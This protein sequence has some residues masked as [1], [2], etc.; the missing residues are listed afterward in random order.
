MTTIRRSNWPSVIAVSWLWFA[1]LLPCQAFLSPAKIAWKQG[2]STAIHPQHPES[3][4]RT[5]QPLQ[6]YNDD[7]EREQI[8]EA[9][10]RIWNSRRGEVRS[11]LKGAESL[12]NFRLANGFVPEL[13][14]DGNPSKSDGK[15]AVTLT[16]FAVAAGAIVL[17]V[18]GRAA[19]VSAVGLDFVNDNPEMQ[20]QINQVLQYAETIDPILKTGLFCL[21]WT[22]VK[23]LC[24][25]AGGI[26]LAFASGILFGG[27]VQGAVMSALGATIG[28]SVAFALA[29][30]DTPVREKA[31]EIV[32][33]NPS[34]RGLEKVVAEE[35][36]KAV[37]TF[38]LAPVLPIPLGMYNYV[39]GITNVRFVDFAGGI[40]LGSLKPY[41]LDSYLGYFGK[42][43]V[44]GTANEGG[45]QDYVLIG[46]LGF[47]VLIGVFASQLASE[48][49]DA[50]Q[51]EQEAED[52]ERKLSELAE[53]GERDDNNDEDDD[54]VT[55]VFGFELPMWVVG[56]QYGLQDAD[57]RMNTLVLQEYDAKVWNCT[58]DSSLFGV[59]LSKSNLPD[60]RN[61]ALLPTSPEM[62][63]KYEGVDFGATTCDG[64]VLSPVLF[65]YFLKFQDPLFDDAV[66]RRERDEEAAARASAASN[67]EPSVAAT[68]SAS[69]DAVQSAV[70]DI[71][72]VAA[73]SA[74]AATASVGS[75]EPSA[76]F[77]EG[78]FLN[79]L[80]ALK[81]ETKQRIE[82]TNK[83][84][85]ELN[86]KSESLP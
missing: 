31:I 79:Q 18:G 6:V 43:M 72:A 48:T 25:D 68:S 24:F 16:A 9:R 2:A 54:V 12:R 40:F 49:W 52:R 11:M 20:E 7:E 57:E 81:D 19:L 17:R 21:G 37:L 60:R 33:E 69:S 27:V 46:V 77:Q 85:A 23:T 56:F 45:L 67:S 55:E 64:L 65:S 80:Q 42:S 13:D 61:P 76:Q 71:V 59:E 38:R 47:S 3:L 62:T 78:V 53:S 58:E 82:E 15:T 50:I 30:A 10:V 1:V 35:G 39:Y 70:Q 5:P 29:K 14:E 8:E 36:L 74:V 63:D 26:V 32:E 4:R 73:A 51:K 28:S 84:L 34:L 41:F 66:F 44:D 86:D 22:F 75:N 83:K